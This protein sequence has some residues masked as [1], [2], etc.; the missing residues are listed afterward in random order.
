MKMADVII[1]VLV[2]IWCGSLFMKYRYFIKNYGIKLSADLSMRSFA[3]TPLNVFA[4]RLHY[5][6]HFREHSIPTMLLTFVTDTQ[7]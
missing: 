4:A 7:L 1:F 5:S 2:N 6:L 3:R